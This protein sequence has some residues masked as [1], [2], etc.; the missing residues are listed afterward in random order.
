MCKFISFLSPKY[1]K[2][3]Q[4]QYNFKFWILIAIIL[5]PVIISIPLVWTLPKLNAALYDE[6]YDME[7]GCPLMLN[8][9]TKTIK[10]LCYNKNMKGCMIEC[11]LILLT[12]NGFLL[13][14]ISMIIITFYAIVTLYASC[15]EAIKLNKMNDEIMF[16]L[17]NLD[18]NVTD[19]DEISSGSND[20]I[21]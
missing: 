7:T 9:C 16:S 21:S 8:N 6:Y 18:D 1:N 13:I 20:N 12:I 4:C 3:T 15:R 19:K 2:H 10:L 14:M 17:N 11:L 5:I